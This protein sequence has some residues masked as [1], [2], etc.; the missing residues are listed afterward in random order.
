M[1]REEQVYRQLKAVQFL[2]AI[3]QGQTYQELSE[4]LGI[5]PIVLNRYIKGH[6]LPEPARAEEILKLRSWERLAQQGKS[7]LRA[8]E[9]G[10]IDNTRLVFHTPFLRTV[11]DLMVMEFPH[12]DKVLTAAVDG[13]PLA[14]HIAACL[15]VGCLFTKRER[16]VG[17]ASFIE[18]HSNLPTG[19]VMNYFL[20]ADALSRDDQV[21]I[22]DDLM[23]SGETQAALVEIAQATKATVVGIFSLIQIGERG[24]R[25][26]RRLITCPIKSLICLPS[27]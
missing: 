17:V 9:D 25:R 11:A 21:L 22:V 3:K 12:P 4:A 20:P 24:Y 15:N 23:R 2:R 26:L 13:I 14:V 18:S 16:E 27:H 1:T 10:F 19:Q 6:V 7:L 8:N 5:S